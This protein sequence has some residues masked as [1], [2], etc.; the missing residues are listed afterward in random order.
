MVRTTWICAAT[1]AAA[2]IPASLLAQ[3]Q[4]AGGPGEWLSR[5]RTART[6]GLGGAFVATADDPLGVLW[7][8]AGLSGMDQNEVRFENARLFEETSINSMSF[9]VPGSWLPSFGVTVVALG[10]GEFEKTNDMNDA[11]GT[12]K[13]GETA[14]LFTLSRLF[15]RRLAVGTNLKLVQQTVEEFSGQGFGLDLGVTYELTPALR[16]GATVANLAGPSLTLRDVEETYATEYRGGVAARL[17]NG[18]ALIALE[19]DHSEGLGPRVHAGAEYWLQ[20]AMAL[21]VGYDDAYG[22]GG[23]TYRFAP[24]YQVDYAV[25]DQALGITHR[26][27]VAYRFGGFFASSRA[28]PQVF[29]PTGEHAVTK[30]ALNARTKAEPEVWTLEIVNKSDE[31]VRRFSGKGQPPAHVQ[32][33]GKDEAGLPLPDGHYR[34]RLHVKDHAGREMVA[35]TRA[36]EIFTTGPQGD[37]PVIP[38]QGT[39]EPET[40]ESR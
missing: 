14:Y 7:N 35:A 38:V 12:F 27:G 31:V 37:V 32:W 24:Q 4:T 17:W 10:S 9:A 33:D 13:Q 15:A 20:P 19:L 2:L 16:I 39:V 21:R 11:L 23:F 22:A 34:Y 5:Y 8:P 29:S 6:L 3:E 18:R 1:L 30:I 28:E 40:K 26:I 25:A 36:I